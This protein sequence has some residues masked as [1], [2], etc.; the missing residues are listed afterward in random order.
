MFCSLSLQDIVFRVENASE[1]MSQVNLHSQTNHF[2]CLQQ[3]PN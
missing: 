3:R 1:F 2:V